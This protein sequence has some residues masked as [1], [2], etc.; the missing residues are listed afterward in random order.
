MLRKNNYYQPI[1]NSEG[2]TSFT[3]DILDTINGIL[4]PEFE[5]NRQ[6]KVTPP[7]VEIVTHI[8][9]DVNSI[10]LN[11][12]SSYKLPELQEIAKKLGITVKKAGTQRNKKKSD[13][14]EE[15]KLK[16]N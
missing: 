14:Y 10:T 8:Q 2:N 1:L 4:K 11:K 7:K 5:I 16:L 13:L 3:F 9:S 6:V 12:E 15:I